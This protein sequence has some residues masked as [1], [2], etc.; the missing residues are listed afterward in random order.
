MAAIIIDCSKNSTRS[1]KYQASFSH[2]KFSDSYQLNGGSLK[3]W[4]FYRSK[5]VRGPGFK[6]LTGA[7]LDNVKIYYIIAA[8]SFQLPRY[9]GLY[10]DIKKSRSMWWPFIWI[11]S[12]VLKPPKSKWDCCLK[13]YSCI[14]IP[15]TR[16][17]IRRLILSAK[18]ESREMMGS[19]PWQWAQSAD[20]VTCSPLQRNSTKSALPSSRARISCRNQLAVIK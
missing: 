2:Q 20:W 1:P 11:L 15:L 7:P 17:P 10:L 13:L 8:S 6:D 9:L 16:S 18:M 12:E 5:S 3:H 19:F 14:W 4:F